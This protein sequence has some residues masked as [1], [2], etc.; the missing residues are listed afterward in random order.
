MKNFLKWAG[1]SC[2]VTLI[3]VLTACSE[4]YTDDPV[5][6]DETVSLKSAG[7]YDSLVIARHPNSSLSPARRM[8]GIS[9]SANTA[10]DI[11]SSTVTTCGG[12]DM[13]FYNEKAYDSCSATS[14]TGTPLIVLN[15]SY[16][17]ADSI[18]VGY[19]TFD[20][21]IYVNQIPSSVIYQSDISCLTMPIDSTY[22][23]DLTATG[24]LT[25][26]TIA[27]IS[28]QC[29]IGNRFQDGTSVS[30]DQNVYIVRT[31]DEDYNM[32]YYVFMIARFKNTDNTKNMTIYY[33]LLS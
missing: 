21:I 9:L 6:S 33:K 4:S 23:C 2:M 16:V 32:Y 18:G 17:T 19:S 31:I 24:K 15:S 3:A 28:S 5:V 11:S 8:Y 27:G 10:I 14:G 25:K 30:S 1:F 13:Y 22:R 7:D 12:Y 26:N 29:V 20:S